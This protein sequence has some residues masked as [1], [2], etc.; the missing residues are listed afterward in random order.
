MIEAV[1]GL[2]ERNIY[3]GV[4]MNRLFNLRTLFVVLVLL[5]SPL[6]LAQSGNDEGGAKEAVKKESRELLEALK[7]YSSEQKAEAIRESRKVMDKLDAQIAALEKQLDE[8]W[9]KMSEAARLEARA[10]L[11]ALASG[12]WRWQSGMGS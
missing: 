7:S 5:A 12:V 3:L 1:A 4:V 8:D 10:N 11:E 9:E 6:V 2:R